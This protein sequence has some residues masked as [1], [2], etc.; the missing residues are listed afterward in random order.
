MTI[1]CHCSFQDR[2]NLTLPKISLIL[3]LGAL[4]VSAQ[5]SNK[6]GW[7]PVANGD[8]FGGDT[9]LAPIP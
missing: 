1:N 9:A 5:H 8:T 3:I 6:V 7:S 4:A 2:S